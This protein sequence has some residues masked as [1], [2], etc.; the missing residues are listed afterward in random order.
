LLQGERGDGRRE[1]RAI[2]EFHSVAQTKLP[3][4]GLRIVLPGNCQSGLRRAVFI[5][6]DQAIEN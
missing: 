3:A 5:Q 1:R 4:L 6:P 2:A